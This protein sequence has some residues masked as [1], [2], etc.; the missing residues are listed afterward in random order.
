MNSSEVTTPPSAYLGGVLDVSARFDSLVASQGFEPH[1]AEFSRL[2]TPI[3]GPAAT[4]LYLSLFDLVAE[5]GSATVDVIGLG[6]S[7]GVGARKARRTVIT[8][9]ERLRK[10]DLVSGDANGVSVRMHA[11]A[12][13]RSPLGTTPGQWSSVRS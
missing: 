2:W 1:S 13:A 5:T 3:L 7:I 11:P 8:G 6:A 12:P 4:A 9:L 10:F